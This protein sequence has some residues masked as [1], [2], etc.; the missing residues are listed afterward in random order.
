MNVIT[1]DV[2]H[3]GIKD[4]ILAQFDP[5]F[6]VCMNTSGEIYW[7]NPTQW[8]P[9]PFRGDFDRDGFLDDV[10]VKEG[11]FTDLTAWNENGETIDYSINGT[12]QYSDILGEYY[13]DDWQPV[14]DFNSD[15][16][17]D[18]LT[19]TFAKSPWDYYI[20]AVN[21][22]SKKSLWNVSYGSWAKSV[23]YHP[24]DLNNNGYF[25]NLLITTSNNQT[26]AVDNDGTLLWQLQTGG[27]R[28]YMNHV[29]TV[30]DLDHD[31]FSDDAVYVAPSN[32]TVYAIDNSSAVLWDFPSSSAYSVKICDYDNDGYYD[33]VVLIEEYRVCILNAAGELI[34]EHISPYSIY[35]VLIRDVTNDGLVDFIVDSRGLILNH[36]GEVLWDTFD[37]LGIPVATLDLNGDGV[38]NESLWWASWKVFLCQWGLP[39]VTLRLVDAS[40]DFQ[41]FE[42]V[43]NEPKSF[44]VNCT[45]YKNSFRYTPIER[46]LNPHEPEILFYIP[47]Q[48]KE[49]I[50]HVEWSNPKYTAYVYYYGF[51]IA[52]YEVELLGIWVIVAYF[53]LGIGACVVA[54][55]IGEKIYRSYK[56]TPADS[57]KRVI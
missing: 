20:G 2:N 17:F 7:V 53:G 10:L 33:E 37:G 31:G 49:W 50:S 54:L 46:T 40:G 57:G 21:Y 3:D 30:G 26:F 39:N 55:V 15:G 13:G 34:W 56:K 14:G 25:D 5:D 38:A 48:F 18:D 42:A 52:S 35:S 47:N 45:L 44:N 51:I 19:Y 29:I 6:I 32:S 23:Y 27:Y 4:I 12:I 36:S 9:H 11:G 22:I 28:M 16:Y 41:L 43:N 1:L 8:A 24:A